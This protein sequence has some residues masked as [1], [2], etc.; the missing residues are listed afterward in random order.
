MADLKG[1]R[2][3]IGLR[4]FS[5]IVLIIAALLATVMGG[6]AFLALVLIFTALVHRELHRITQ[7]PPMPLSFI[8][9]GLGWVAIVAAW[10]DAQPVAWI[11]FAASLLAAA[12]LP[13]WRG[14]SVVWSVAGTLYVIAPALALVALREQGFEIIVWMFLVIWATDTGAYFVGSQLRGP[15]LWPSVSPNKTWSGALGG[16]VVGSL[17]GALVLRLFDVPDALP[18]LVL[19]S[20]L[21][22]VSGQLG[23]LAESAW[24]RH[25]N[26]KDTGSI[27]P[28]HGGVMDRLDSLVSAS[29][30]LWGLV[31]FER[32][33]F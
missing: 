29:L 16:A 28:G 33:T 4:I 24:K 23:D 18:A 22:S 10:L 20:L 14:R 30:V 2:R 6:L 15:K 7:A 32:V 27:I 3:T 17:A 11:F 31:V 19:I 26:V 5:A 25:F 13:L 21:V 12:L 8:L 1:R 9:L